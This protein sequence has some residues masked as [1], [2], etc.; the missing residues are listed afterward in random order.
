MSLIKKENFN[1][2]EEGPLGTTF[3][4]KINGVVEKFK[5]SIVGNHNIENILSYILVLPLIGAFLISF[6]PS[7]NR[8]MLRS[9]ALNCSCLIYLP[10]MVLGYNEP[11]LLQD[12]QEFL[13]QEQRIES[14]NHT[15]HL[16]FCK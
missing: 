9:V 12:L 10:N 6:I 7:S 1:L 5:T 15:V 11:I 4:L 8:S 2:V 16:R 3:E 13:R 14:K